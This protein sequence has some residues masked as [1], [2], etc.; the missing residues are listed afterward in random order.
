MMPGII[1]AWFYF[2]GEYAAL[3]F[4]NEIKFT[5]LFAVK[6]IELKPMSVQFLCNGILVNGSKINVSLII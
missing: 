1:F 4:N 3:V 2:D 6:V 5:L